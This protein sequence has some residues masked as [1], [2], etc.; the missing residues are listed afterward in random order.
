[1]F[2]SKAI[3]HSYGGK[4]DIVSIAKCGVTVKPENTEEIKK[5]IL[6]LYNMPKDIREEL[7]K[8]GKRFV[9]NNF[10][11]EKLANIYIEIGDNRYTR[12]EMDNR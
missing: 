2:A 4:K 10:T 12:N 9:L 5:A 1:M 8:N 6:Q 11:Y 3:L 7:G